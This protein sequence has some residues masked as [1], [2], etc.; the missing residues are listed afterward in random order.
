M[1]LA[2]LGTNPA[3]IQWTTSVRGYGLGVLL[4]LVSFGLIYK[5]ATT[6][7]SRGMI[8]LAALASVSSVQLV[9]GNAAFVFAIIVAGAMVALQTGHRR[10]SII[11]L[12]IGLGAALL[13]LPYLHGIR[14]E[15][16]WNNVVTHAGF[17]LSVFWKKLSLTLSSARYSLRWIWVGI[18]AAVGL[19]TLWSRKHSRPNEGCPPV[20]LFLPR[21]FSWAFRILHISR[22]PAV[23]NTTVGYTFA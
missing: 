11:L 20:Q 7:A 2:F 23:P 9:F 13:L 14:R 16:S 4:I 3:F 5:V 6:E 15:E 22:H 17:N 21:V 12:A 19:A 10:R 8:G 1:S 18:L